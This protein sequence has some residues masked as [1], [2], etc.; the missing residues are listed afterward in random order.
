MLTTEEHINDG[1]MLMLGE[2][3]FQANLGDVGRRQ[4][5]ERADAAFHVK[6]VPY[7]ESDRY[8]VCVTTSY[9][10]TTDVV[11]KPEDP[12]S[13]LVRTGFYTFTPRSSRRVDSSS[14]RTVRNTR[15]ANRST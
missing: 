7:E 1:F 15:S 9:E 14:P 4:R 6:E 8:G 13:N 10:E 2:N 3:I 5:E 11:E 12:P